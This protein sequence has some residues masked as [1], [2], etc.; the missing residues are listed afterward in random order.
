MAAVVGLSP[1]KR[2]IDI[3][4]GKV[5]PH[6]A[7]EPDKECLFWGSALEPIIRDR[8]AV[9]YEAKVIPPSDIRTLFPNT[10]SWKGQTIVIG[11]QEWMLG[12][13]D[14][15][16]PDHHSGLEIK[17][18][19]FKSEEW[20]KEGTDEIPPH[21]LVQ[22]AW[23]MAVTGLPAWNVAVLFSGNKLQSYRVERNEELLKY[24]LE[25]GE[26]FW[27]DCVLKELPPPVDASESYGRYLSRR[28]SIGN[29]TLIKETPELLEWT[30]K[31][32]A[33][34]ESIKGT[35]ESE[36]EAK[37]NLAALLGEADGCK[38]TL[39]KVAWVRSKPFPVTDWEKAFGEASKDKTS[40]ERETII[41]ANTA[42][43]QRSPY[44]RG[45]WKK[46]GK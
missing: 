8:Y 11:P 5:N 46:E 18:S 14:G 28:F 4:E 24:L 10:R 39:G 7:P 38:T 13:P 37:N 25:A 3:F 12:T 16:L 36:Q 29:G 41:K 42:T 9:R 6:E 32:K 20:G 30:K 44:V 27:N 34:Q 23:Y 1:W 21:Y 22:V 35:E 43:Q 15:I 19:A 45:Y 31:L 33:V 26:S 2:P 17:C 40:E